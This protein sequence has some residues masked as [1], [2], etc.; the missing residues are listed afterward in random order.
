MKLNF[1]KI[2]PYLFGV[3]ACAIWWYM[4]GIFPTENAII[5]STLTVAGIFV[6][7][8]ATSKAILI[9]MDSP[10]ITELRKSGYINEL[11]A[12]IGHAIWLN[13]TFCVIGVI[14][15]FS[16]QAAQWYAILWIG[17]SVSSLA[18]FIRVTRIMLKIFKHN[19]Q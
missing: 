18:A 3:L 6:G 13:L 4:D 12:Y 8:L 19:H 2:Y 9:S 11:V 10:L 16:F 15:Y 1:E 17:F 5:S 7:F 14:G